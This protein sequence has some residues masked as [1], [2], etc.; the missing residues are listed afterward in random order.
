M[1]TGGRST[2]ATDQTQAQPDEAAV[3]AALA[4]YTATCFTTREVDLPE[5]DRFDNRFHLGLDY[6]PD[7]ATNVIGNKGLPL[8]P[9][10]S[11]STLWN[12][13]FVEAKM[14]K[15]PWTPELAVVTGV[16]WGWPSGAGC[17][18]AT[19]A[20]YLRSFLLGALDFAKGPTSLPEGP[21]SFFGNAKAFLARFNPFG[22]DPTSRS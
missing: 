7:L 2:I 4:I 15:R 19:R 1:S 18:I 14:A 20:E 6:R 10:L 16:I 17:L 12:T 13:G 21:K 9:G 3:A 5:D 22:P 8:P 11:G